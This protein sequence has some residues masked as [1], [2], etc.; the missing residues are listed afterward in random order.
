MFALVVAIDRYKSPHIP[1]LSGC[2]NDGIA[3]VALLQE[4]FPASQITCLY[5]EEATRE[6][7]VSTFRRTFKE[8]ASIQPG[9]PMLLFYAGHGSRVSAPPE[10]SPAHRNIETICPYD[11][12]TVDSS[13]NHIHGI[14]D[15]TIDGLLC[16]LSKEK[17][18]NVVSPVNLYT[19]LV[20][21]S[22]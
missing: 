1:N 8:N 11:E 17:G 7:V 15:Y 14:P 5:S 20:L 13:G 19:K 4:K 16:E 2:E 12:E 18:N 10:W 21:T 22:K 9:D 3:M 6:R